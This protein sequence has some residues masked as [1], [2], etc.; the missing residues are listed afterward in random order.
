VRS[1]PLEEA[2]AELERGRRERIVVVAVVLLA[3]AATVVVVLLGPED[4]TVGTV[5]TAVALLIAVAA[6]VASLVIRERRSVRASRA[7]V[8]ARAAHAADE[9]RERTLGALH[10][11]SR[12]I[13][14]TLE[15]SEVV[16][17]AVAVTAGLVDAATAALWLRIG[18][19]LAVAA[20]YGP[21]APPRGTRR[22][23]TE[24]D[25]AVVERG[26]AI[27]GGRGSEWG[28]GPA[29]I[30]A[31]LALPERVIGVVV[32]QR[33]STARAFGEDDRLAVAL[34][35]EHIALALRNATALDR[36]RQRSEAFRALV[37][38]PPDEPDDLTRWRR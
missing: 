20:V 25:R 31:P 18:D 2:Q 4:T 13:A 26:V 37:G 35:A 24:I 28:D 27:T 33:G 23:M 30:T 22:D 15:L 14:A 12:A 10:A 1:D 6:H 11:A 8:A 17:R 21:D 5:V 29:T 19:G 9:A 36:E 32:V 34:L 3:M 38:A 7:L 16:D